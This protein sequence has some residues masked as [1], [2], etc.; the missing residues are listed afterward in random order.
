MWIDAAKKAQKKKK[1]LLKQSACVISLDICLWIVALWLWLRF[2]LINQTSVCNASAEMDTKALNS[3]ADGPK[4][5]RNVFTLCW[6]GLSADIWQM[7]CFGFVR[8]TSPLTMKHLANGSLSRSAGV[9]ACLLTLPEPTSNRREHIIWARA[10]VVR[11]LIR[12]WSWSW[13]LAIKQ[14]HVKCCRIS[15]SWNVRC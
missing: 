2:W 5:N 12:S 14:I 3:R 11:S 15:A 13:A 9:M 8:V 6:L 1:L 7:R 10:T 4:K